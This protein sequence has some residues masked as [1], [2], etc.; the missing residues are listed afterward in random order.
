MQNVEY[1]FNHES[2]ETE[3]KTFAEKKITELYVHDQKMAS[4]KKMLIHFLQTAVRDISSCYISLKINPDVI[5]SEIINLV[6]SLF[7]SLEIPMTE[8]K[9][10]IL[11]KDKKV[12][13]FDKK[14]YSK[15]AALLNNAGLIF[16]FDLDFALSQ[17]DSFKAF[18]DRID[19]ALTLYPNHIDFPQIE[20]KS[21][22]KE[23]CT[24]TY[25]S[26]DI[27]YS[28]KLAL[29]LKIFYTAGR[30]VPWFNF[31][32]K[33][34]KVA[35]SKFFSDFAEWLECNNVDLN[36]SEKIE[37]LTHK[38]IEKMQLL[39][40]EMK[41]E[42]K[43]KEDLYTAVKDI[44]N[45]YGAFSRADQENEETVLDLSY[46]PEDLLSPATLNIQSFCDN[47]C[48]DYCKIRVFAGEEEPE[49]ALL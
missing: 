30:A 22:L 21:E 16:G 37:S 18:R 38:E 8:S 13:L 46:N 43:H 23:K 10:K 11:E 45:L 27:S 20:K 19:F 28:K 14:L 5:D 49:Y 1:N 6:S 4:D 12:F 7:C 40:L 48:M 15:K 31:V 29:A 17:G 2:L 39:F 36:D 41:F 26:Q 9:T 44:V 47:V 3:L 33:P 25:S 24:G 35:P 42:E 32:L 34:L